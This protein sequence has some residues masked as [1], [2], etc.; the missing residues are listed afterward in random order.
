MYIV[1]S[2]DIY[3]PSR[4]LVR[5]GIVD[6]KRLHTLLM[7]S[8]ERL[9]LR[10]HRRIV[11][12]VYVNSHNTDAIR[13]CAVRSPVVVIVV[14]DVLESLDLEIRAELFVHLHFEDVLLVN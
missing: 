14:D 7:L 3:S 8:I 2:F 1:L 13:L 10:N 6:D 11:I 5:I 12:A 4:V 9:S